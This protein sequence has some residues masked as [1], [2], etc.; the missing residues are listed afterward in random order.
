MANEEKCAICHVADPNYK[1]PKCGVRY[2]SLKCYKNAEKHNHDTL[3]ASEEKEKKQCS[4]IKSSIK[5]NE[6][7]SLQ[8]E[9]YN[10]IYNGTPELQHLL[11]YN[12]V[13][14]HLHKVYRILCTDI[15]GNGG[16]SSNLNAE[17]RKQL[18]LDYLN[19]MLYGGIHYNE[20]IEEFCQIFLQ[21]LND[22]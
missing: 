4:E 16:S 17:S 13:K 5:D 22:M 6:H 20:A 12:T 10:S 14:F 8:T 1:C 19:T 15:S 11:K 21:K 2:C 9:S 3:I 7:G 18:A